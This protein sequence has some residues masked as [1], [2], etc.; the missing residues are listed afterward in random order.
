MS[1]EICDLQLHFHESHIHFCKNKEE[2]G[3]IELRFHKPA[4]SILRFFNCKHE[5]QNATSRLCIQLTYLGTNFKDKMQV[6]FLFLLLA[7]PCIFSP[8][9][10]HISQILIF[11]LFPCMKSSNK[12]HLTFREPIQLIEFQEKISKIS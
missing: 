10:T 3:A 6:Y 4:Y 8:T 2:N 9:L 12:Y 11:T 1:L 5:F 7:S